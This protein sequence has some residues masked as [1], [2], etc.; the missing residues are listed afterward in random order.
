MKYLLCL[1]GWFLAGFG[2]GVLRVKKYTKGG[3]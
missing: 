3:E 2:L 1:L